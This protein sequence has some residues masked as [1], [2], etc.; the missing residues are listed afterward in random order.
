MKK[1]RH[2]LILT[3]FVLLI[4]FSACKNDPE[5]KD[6]LV[7]NRSTP[8]ILKSP[9]TFPPMK[10]PSYNPLTNEGVSL[11]R[12]LFND[13][14]LSANNTQACARCH[15]QNASFVDSAVKFSKGSNG[16][17][18]FRN[19]MPIFNLGYATAWFWDGKAKTL[20]EL[21]FHPITSQFEMNQDPAELVNELSQNKEYKKLYDAAFGAGDITFD[22]TTKALAQ[23]MRT[24]IAYTPKPLD[25]M[26]MSA[27]EKRGLKVFL[28][29]DKGDCFHCHELGNFMTNYKF[30][31]NGLNQ[32][33][34]LDA[35]LYNVTGKGIDIG[36]FKT[37]A[38]I[39]IKYTSPYMHD[40]R[41]KTLRE[42]LD[43]YDHGFHYNPITNGNLDVNLIKHFDKTTQKPIPRKWSEQDKLDIIDFINGLVDE[44]LL[45]NPEFGG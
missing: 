36:R 32:N 23:F 16:V 25:T 18:G 4:A 31:N 34:F 5:I 7:P 29:E 2:L 39:N 14:M 8:Y 11:G 38:L 45:T 24:I 17:N 43:F 9:P 33:S 44:S 1:N 27:S 10:I 40:G 22:K 35:G 30:A 12:K 42:V 28:A 37:P 3:G 19:S 20:E 6:D 41:F 21:V 26:L 15:Q 13:P